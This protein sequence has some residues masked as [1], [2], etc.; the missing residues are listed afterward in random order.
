ML[1]DIITQT[2]NRDHQGKNSYIPLSRIIHI[3]RQD[4]VRASYKRFHELLYILD[5]HIFYLPK[6]TCF[7]CNNYSTRISYTQ[8][9]GANPS[10]SLTTIFSNPE[11]STFFTSST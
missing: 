4:A 5:A 6:Q 11:T 8:S 7:I 10:K 9:G 2:T 1:T 3:L